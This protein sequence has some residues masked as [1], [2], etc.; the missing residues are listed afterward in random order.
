[1]K[2][3][4]LRS[5]NISNTSL[6]IYASGI[7]KQMTNNSDVFV[8]PSPSLEELE[9][10]LIEFRRA[11]TNAKYRD[12]RAILLRNQKRKELFRVL[13][14]LSFYVSY[15][16]DG[17]ESLIL[18]SGYAPS[19]TPG[20]TGDNPKPDNFRAKPEIGSN[21][22]DLLVNPWRP[23]RMYQFEYRKKD[24]NDPWH[25]QL[26]S[27]SRCRITNLERFQEYEFRVSYIGKTAKLFYSDI[28]SSYV[29]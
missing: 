21:S 26:S 20:S 5:H 13:R 11:V 6:D 19:R 12:Q 1:M 28:I 8:D 27:N 17:D 3:P 9:T 7:L 16:A 24:G 4:T 29:Y 22:I 10:I 25:T 2:R 14:L 18:L 23:A 15:I